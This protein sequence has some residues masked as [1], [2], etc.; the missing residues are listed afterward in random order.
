MFKLGKGVVWRQWAPVPLR[1][2]IGY[3]FL[4]HGQ[5]EAEMEELRRQFRETS[6]PPAGPP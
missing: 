5:L 3:G 1:L 4:A 2:V 6:V